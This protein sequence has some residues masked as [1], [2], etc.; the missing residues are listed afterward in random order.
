MLPTQQN[1]SLLNSIATTIPPAETAVCRT[2]NF[3]NCNSISRMR[4]NCS[5]IIYGQSGFL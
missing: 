5:K 4:K 3:L 1:K 2:R